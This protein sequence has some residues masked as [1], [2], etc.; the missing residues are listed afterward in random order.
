MVF[1]MGIFYGGLAQIIAGISEF[2]KGNTFGM[3]AFSS[4]GLFWLS[5]V[6]LKVFPALGWAESVDLRSMGAYLT[7]WGIFTAWMF[8]ST[9]Q[10]HLFGYGRSHE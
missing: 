10:C 1:G 9:V 2:K 6:A 8:L 3:T 4:Y 7:M 5:L